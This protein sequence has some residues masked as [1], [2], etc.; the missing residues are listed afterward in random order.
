[1]SKRTRIWDITVPKISW[2]LL[3]FTARFQSS[4]KMLDVGEFHRVHN[5]EG[6]LAS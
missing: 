4:S 2:V 1:M 6:F 3:S 5:R